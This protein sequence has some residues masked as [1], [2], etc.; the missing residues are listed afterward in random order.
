[1]EVPKPVQKP[2]VV[3]VEVPKKSDAEIKLEAKFLTLTKDSS[4]P[5]LGMFAK[6]KTEG[7]NSSLLREFV[8]LT[9]PYATE[10]V[11]QIVSV[12]HVIAQREPGLFKSLNEVGTNF[13]KGNF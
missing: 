11:S 7:L 12:N 3:V 13:Q 9:K 4:K 10:K 5:L 8:S 2:V 1:M 6:L